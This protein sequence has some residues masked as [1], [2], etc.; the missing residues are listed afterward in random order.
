MCAANAARTS[1]Y[2]AQ[3][4]QYEDARVYS[5]GWRNVMG[6]AATHQSAQAPEHVGAWNDYMN[7]MDTMDHQ[8]QQSM[9]IPQLTTRTLILVIQAATNSP[10]P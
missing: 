7:V 1:A 3:Q 10:C 5:Y 9:R 4:G 8:L 2:L 6:R